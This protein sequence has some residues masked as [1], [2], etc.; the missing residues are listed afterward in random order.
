MLGQSPLNST[1]TDH[2]EAVSNPRFGDNVGM[3]GGEPPGIRGLLE[4][5]L[6]AHMR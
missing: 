4:A 3:G 6:R 2:K 5:S 1:D